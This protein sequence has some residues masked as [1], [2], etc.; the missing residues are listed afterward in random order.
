MEVHIMFYCSEKSWSFITDTCYPDSIAKYTITH[1]ANGTWSS[2]YYFNDSN[3]KV[4]DDSMLF[5]EIRNEPNLTKLLR[6]TVCYGSPEEI[7][8]TIL[9][10]VSGMDMLLFSF[11]KHDPNQLFTRGCDVSYYSIQQIKWNDAMNK[12]YQGVPVLAKAVNDDG[13]VKISIDAIDSDNVYHM[14]MSKVLQ[15]KPFEG[16]V[17]VDPSEAN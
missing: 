12:I 7:I 16:F 5:R 3:E 8:E 17:I 15:G 11:A 10:I 13:N 6:E 14:A 4:F 1:E 9:R 2:R